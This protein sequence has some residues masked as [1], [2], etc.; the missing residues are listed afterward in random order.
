MTYTTLYQW[1]LTTEVILDTQPAVCVILVV[2]LVV[3]TGESLRKKL[4]GD[5]MF[6]HQRIFVVQKTT[7]NITRHLRALLHYSA[8]FPERVV[9][10]H[11]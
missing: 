6:Q 9:G 11:W 7:S 8:D 5:N 1:N 10:S 3:I 4:K 2:L